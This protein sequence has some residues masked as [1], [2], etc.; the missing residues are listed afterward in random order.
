M[1]IIART[2]GLTGGFVKVMLTRLNSKVMRCVQKSPTLSY[3][4][5]LGFLG[6]ANYFR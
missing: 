5:Q 6:L 3:L 1:L 2:I 4:T